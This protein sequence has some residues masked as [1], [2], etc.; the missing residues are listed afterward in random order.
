MKGS[1]SLDAEGNLYESEENFL[2]SDQPDGLLGST[3]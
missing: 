2:E 3:C 1:C